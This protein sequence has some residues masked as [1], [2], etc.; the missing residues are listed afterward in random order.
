MREIKKRET[1]DRQTAKKKHEEE[2]FAWGQ[3]RENQK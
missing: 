3:R 2:E 1:R